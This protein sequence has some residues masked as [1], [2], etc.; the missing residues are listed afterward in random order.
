L[1]ASLKLLNEVGIPAIRAHLEMLTDHLCERLQN[2]AYQVV[3]SRRAGEKSQIVCI[4]HLAGLSSMDLYAHLKKRNIVT[5]P[6]GGRLRVSPHL[7]NT[8]EEMD[9]LVNALP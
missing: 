7:Y 5:A 9:E 2:T 1:E 3:S 8:I 4:R 6:R